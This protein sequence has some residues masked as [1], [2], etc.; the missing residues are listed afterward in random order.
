MKIK[1]LKFIAII[2]VI[3]SVIPFGA[4][5]Q[6]IVFV[7]SDTGKAITDISSSE[8]IYAEIEFTPE[9]SGKANVIA[10]GYDRDGNVVSVPII[11]PINTA[12]G[13]KITYNTTTF[14][15]GIANYIKLFVWGADNI[16][17]ILSKNGVIGTEYI[18][19]SFEEKFNIPADNCE[20]SPFPVPSNSEISLKNLISAKDGVDV[21]D[22]YFEVASEQVGDGT[23]K[24]EYIPDRSN[25]LN[26]LVKF[27]GDGVLK[28]TV[29]DL[30]FVFQQSCISM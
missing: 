3:F 12:S 15:K 17:P 26:S 30:V 28:L 1:F 6:T 9:E 16:K 4:F 13:K 27:T 2:T 10:V 24:V 21:S 18:K 19:D 20:S 8:K 5:A 22:K 11:E 23:A 14:K 29:Q 7:D 25:W